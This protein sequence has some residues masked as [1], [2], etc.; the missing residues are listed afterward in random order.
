M[1]GVVYG[2][3]Y[4]ESDCGVQLENVQSILGQMIVGR[5]HRHTMAHGGTNDREICR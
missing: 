3:K 5:V 2:R 1:S 4:G